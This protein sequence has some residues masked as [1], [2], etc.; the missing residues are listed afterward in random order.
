MQDPRLERLSKNLHQK[1]NATVVDH[2]LVVKSA[3]RLGE[4][5]ASK[6]KGAKNENNKARGLRC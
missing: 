6:P 1:R 3:K 4:S 5:K 2:A